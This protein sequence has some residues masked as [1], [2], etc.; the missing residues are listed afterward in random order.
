MK[1]GATPITDID[2]EVLSERPPMRRALPSTDEIFE[3]VKTLTDEEYEESLFVLAYDSN[4]RMCSLERV[5]DSG[6][7]MEESLSEALSLIGT[8]NRAKSVVLIH[9]L[10]MGNTAAASIDSDL[11]ESRTKLIERLGLTLH[12]YV[13]ISRWEYRSLA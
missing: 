11:I 6:Y 7:S 3:M 10:A 5:S 9:A 1:N 4:F 12:D 2:G 13:E 8:S